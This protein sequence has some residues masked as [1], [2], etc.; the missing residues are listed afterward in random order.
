[1]EQHFVI[2]GALDSVTLKDFQTQLLKI[3][4]DGTMFDLY[5]TPGPNQKKDAEHIEIGTS[6]ESEISQN[7][8]NSPLND[9]SLYF[10]QYVIPLIDG[11]SEHEFD[12]YHNDMFFLVQ[13]F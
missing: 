11:T 3:K 12:R 9:P 7:N 5:P 1:M 4:F 10:H 6:K 2:K 13:L 8:L